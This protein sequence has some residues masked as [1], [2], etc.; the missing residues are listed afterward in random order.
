MGD[1]P[2]MNEWWFTYLVLPVLIICARIADVS[3][4]TIR[5]IFLNRGRKVIA[6]VLGFFEVLIWIMAV[7]QVMKNLANPVCYLA[8]GVGFAAG[9]YIGM[10]IEEKVA[11]GWLAMRI[12]TQQACAELALALRGEGYG[13]TTLDGQGGEGPVSVVFMVIR[14]KHLPKIV[15]HI[16]RHKPD[17]FYAVEEV[18]SVAGGTLAADWP[19]RRPLP[20]RRWGE[21]DDR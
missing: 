6:P 14:R 16:R 19:G 1:W 7:S 11:A 18:R 8:Y 12:I 5:I 2:F 4:D 3:L 17:A 13:V 21:P 15:A 20:L 9:N 10:L